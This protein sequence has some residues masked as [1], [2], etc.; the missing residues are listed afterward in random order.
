MT[1]ITPGP[2]NRGSGSPPDALGQQRPVPAE[3]A[4]GVVKGEPIGH[5]PDVG[6]GPAHSVL[7]AVLGRQLPGVFQE[8]LDQ[9][10]QHIPYLYDYA[11]QPWKTQE[12][13]RM[14]M[15]RLY[16]ATPDGYCGDEDNGQ[17]SAWYVFSAMGFYP[18]CPASSQYA[19]GSPLFRKV[20]IT[21]PDG[22]RITL[23]APDNTPDAP[24]ISSMT[25][26]GREWNH[27]FLEFSDFKDRATIVF[28][29]GRTPDERRGTAPEDKPYS[30]SDEKN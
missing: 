4:F 1:N 15:D 19:V 9:P 27:N 29:M 7:G 14:V 25:V 22:A 16:S 3:Q 21:K 26:N 5:S 12:K 23:E 24:Y 8:G 28:R 6:H 17:T 2:A 10:A 13:V 18:V 20:V 30:F 11:G